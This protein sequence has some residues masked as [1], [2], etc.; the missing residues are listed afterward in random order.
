MGYD[1]DMS[2]RSQPAPGPLRP[3][4]AALV[5]RFAPEAVWLFGSRARGDHR[6]DSDWDL[7]LALSDDALE[8]DLD[9][10]AAWLVARGFGVRTTI[11]TVRSG[12]LDD[13]WGVPNTVGYDLARDGC[14]LDV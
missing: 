14:R 1:R 11:L 3:L 13:A 9:P 2:G 12:E 8:E 7:V 4:L 6:L 5:H 10:L